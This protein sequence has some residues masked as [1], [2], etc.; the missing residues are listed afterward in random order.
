MIP[1]LHNVIQTPSAQIFAITATVRSA[2]V[3]G[4]LSTAEELLTQE[5]DADVNNYVSYANRAFVMARKLNWDHALQDANKAR[6]TNSAW[7]S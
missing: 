5:I 2:C 1:G 6:Y 4:D 7:T 3:T